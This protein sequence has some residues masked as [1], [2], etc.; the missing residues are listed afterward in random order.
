MPMVSASGSDWTPQRLASSD[1][2]GHVP[3]WQSLE[4]LSVHHNSLE[5]L[6]AEQKA[7]I[8]ALPSVRSLLLPHG[9]GLSYSITLWF[10]EG[11]DQVSRQDDI[12]EEGGEKICFCS[13]WKAGDLTTQ[14]LCHFS[15]LHFTAVTVLFLNSKCSFLFIYLHHLLPEHPK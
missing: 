9:W 7:Q 1:P 4:N 13:V 3:R 11:V 12:A 5:V 15:D 8:T 14:S 10:C 6:L 2:E